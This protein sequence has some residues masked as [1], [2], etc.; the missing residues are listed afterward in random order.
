MVEVEQAGDLPAAPDAVPGPEVAVADDL[1]PS[2]HA[3]TAG[4]DALVR[5][6]V[7]GDR[8]VVAAQEARPVAQS[9]RRDDL[10]PPTGAGLAVHPREHL[11]IAPGTDKARRVRTPPPSRGPSRPS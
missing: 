8:I 7:T 6:A 9:G 10:R 4:P 5:R 1:T 3:R 2:A 11:L